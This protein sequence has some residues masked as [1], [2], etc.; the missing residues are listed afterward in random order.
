MYRPGP[1]AHMGSIILNWIAQACLVATSQWREA[2]CPFLPGTN[3]APLSFCSLRHA[4]LLRL[5]RSQSAA[6]GCSRRLLCRTESLSVA[7]TCLS[8]HCS[9]TIG[10][11]GRH[12]AR[13]TTAELWKTLRRIQPYKQA[14]SPS[15]VPPL[16]ARCPSQVEAPFHRL[17]LLPRP[18][19]A[20][21]PRPLAPSAPPLPTPI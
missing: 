7:S 16:P 5:T 3:S 10:D 17:C 4:L 8:L 21:R 1:Q 12:H 2:K 20:S 13:L 6:L 14:R 19:I 18:H 11:D 9:I 15:P